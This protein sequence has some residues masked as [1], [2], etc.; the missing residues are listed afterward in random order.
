[1]ILLHATGIDK[2]MH[3]IVILLFI[4]SKVF[5]IYSMHMFEGIVSL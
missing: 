3:C 2:A 5:G 4:P 1:M